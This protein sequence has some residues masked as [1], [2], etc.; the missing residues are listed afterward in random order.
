MDSSSYGAH[1]DMLGARFGV[2]AAEDGHLMAFDGAC[3]CGVCWLLQDATGDCRDR[4]VRGG[5]ALI[6]YRT[7]L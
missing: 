5:R 6:I 1:A 3:G 7:V 2:R 4:A